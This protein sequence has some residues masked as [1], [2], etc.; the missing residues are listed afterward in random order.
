M[1]N[2]IIAS[3]NQ[4]KIITR[5]GGTG[6]KSILNGKCG[7]AWCFIN[8][9]HDLPLELFTL[10]INSVD[11]ETVH[12][13][14]LNVTG[15]C[16]IK[17]DLIKED[18]DSGN[19]DSVNQAFQNFAG[20]TKTQIQGSL[21]KTMEGHQRQLLG[22]LSV[23]KLYKDRTE[24]SASVKRHVE[25]DVRKMGFTIVS[26]TI[27]DITDNN[28]YMDALGQNQLSKVLKNA[29]EGEAKNKAQA[30]KTVA[31]VT[32]EAD[33]IVAE[34]QRISSV[35]QNEIRQKESESMR[36]L[37]VK[38]EE[39]NQ[40]VN[41]SRASADAAYDVAYNTKKQEIIREETKQDV[42][43]S[44]ILLEVEEIKAMTEQEIRKG[45]SLSILVKDKNEAL[46]V[47]AIAR[48]NANKIEWVGQAEADAIHAQGN[49]GAE[50]L[51]DKAKAF[52]AFGQAAIVQSIV[53]KLPTIAGNLTKPLAKTDKM[54]IISSDG[55]TGS[56]ITE[57][58][59]KVMGQI[60]GV[61]QAIT[62]VNLTKGLDGSELN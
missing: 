41:Q 45:Q 16:Q 60:P 29:K 31:T 61:V 38:R 59:A 30:K 1:G 57:D 49:A 11:A 39:Y 12:G 19:Y 48:A 28:G 22:T 46:G 5:G 55:N 14:K 43:K 52:K 13:V 34:F 58:V 23:E 24:F 18:L 9:V 20:F 17:V 10:V 53:E 37:Y 4:V 42:I 27:T 26:Y 32:S 3:P 15:V 8:E 2:C 25:Q 56:K 35:A 51:Q 21:K 47:E 50:I 7:W 36:D 54:M 33:K 62:G 6:D 44:G 40:I